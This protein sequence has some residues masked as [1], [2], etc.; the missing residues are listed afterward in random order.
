MDKL[1]KEYED[2]IEEVCEK[3]GY[4]DFDQDGN[5]SFKTVLK[6][7]IPCMLDGVDEEKKKLFFDMLK[8]TPIVI[9][10]ANDTT[11]TDELNKKYIGDVHPNVEFEEEDLG[12]Y[13]KKTPA[14]AYVSD[15]V[16]DDDLNLTGKKS[17]IFIKKVETSFEKKYFGTDINVAHLAHEL[18]HAWN[19]QNNQYSLDE[20]GNIVSR[21]GTAK[22]IYRIEQDESG[23]N[24]VKRLKTTGLFIEEEMNTLEEEKVMAKYKEI[25]LEQM[26]KDYRSELIPSSYQGPNLIGMTEDLLEVINEEELKNWRMYGDDKYIDGINDLLSHT[27]H[28]QKRNEI[29]GENST[30]DLSYDNKEK[31]FAE[32]SDQQAIEFLQE[33]E[34]V[35]FADV[36]EMKPI[37]RIDNVMEQMYTFDA[38]KMRFDIFDPKQKQEFRDCLLAIMKEGYILIN[39]AKEIEEE[40]S[41]NPMEQIKNVVQDVTA[42]RVD[43]VTKETK[44]SIKEMQNAKEEVV[45]GDDEN[46]QRD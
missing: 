45:Q 16:L 31:I 43:T 36:S 28:W 14:G 7:L 22:H 25:S 9:L 10:E 3:Y 32:V 21:T 42:S 11:T 17:Y 23:K 33:N 29:F 41:N 12:E 1:T 15:F 8:S 26:R 34:D 5:D 20:N 27:N 44:E 4:D 38:I 46:E 19:A 18:G 39:Q 30:D 37:E 24:I 40:K 6:K 35:F 2:L 13:S